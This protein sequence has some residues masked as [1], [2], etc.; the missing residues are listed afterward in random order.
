[1]PE[2]HHFILYKLHI[3]EI[4]AKNRRYVFS[5]IGSIYVCE[6]LIKNYFSMSDIIK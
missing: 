3:I 2:K 6:F 5:W 4:L 1:M